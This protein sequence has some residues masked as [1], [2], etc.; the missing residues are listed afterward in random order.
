MPLIPIKLPPGVFANGT[1]Y[2]AQGRWRDANLVRWK[3]GI[4][5][6]VGGW[7]ERL[8]VASDAPRGALAWADLAG[9]TRFAVGTF[10]ALYSITAAGAVTDITPVG[11]TAGDL[12][13]AVNIGYGGGVYGAGFYGTPRPDAGNYGEATTWALDNWGENL[14]A[15][16]SADGVIY[17]WDLDPGNDATA[18]TNAPTGNLSMMVTDERF[19]F[20]FGAGGNRRKVQWSDREANTVW[21]PAATNQAGDIELQTSGQ[22]M[23]GVRVSG[24][25]LILTDVDAHVANYIGPPFVYSFR[26]VGTSCGAVSRKAVAVVD[27][28]AFWMVPGGFFAYRGGVAEEVTCDV[29]DRVFADLNSAQVSKIYAVA[30][31]RNSEIWWFY[32]SSGSS[33]NDRYVVYDYKGNH[34]T[35]GALSRTAAIDAGVFRH[36][37]WFGADGMAY[38]HEIGLNYD[39]GEVYAESAPF[40]IGNGDQVMT[41]LN[42]YPDEATQGDVTATFRTRFYPNGDETEHGP[43]SMATPTN[44]RF[45]GRQVSVRMTGARLANWRVGVPRLEVVSRGRR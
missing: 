42:L 29:A 33:E 14:L 44:V 35:L 17:E 39:D 13:A 37:I 1:A 9:D 11:L 24:Q 5:A 23:C 16:S 15:C 45:T 27:Q 6:P 36:P 31:A 7:Q 10:D 20:A 18:L 2:E 25:A 19:V 32:P 40:E 21:T 26:R 3:D 28:G 4:L 34:W 22:I 12:D 8:S 43:Y 38:D 41:A 30:N